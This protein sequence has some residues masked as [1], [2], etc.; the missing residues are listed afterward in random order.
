M[1]KHMAN[2]NYNPDVLNCIANLSNDEVFTPP[3]L[4]N[5]VL[6]LLPQDLF[7]NPNTTFLDPFSKTGV[8][9]REIVKRLDRGLESQIPDRQ[10]RIDHILHTQVYGIAITELTSYL[11]RRSVYCSKHANGKYSVSR[12]NTESGNILYVNR[13]HTW[14]DGKCKYC[15]ASQSVYDRG[16]EAEQYAY[17]F[18]HTD[19]PKQFFGNMK[20]DVIIGNPPYQL[21]DGGQAA[22]AKP[23]YNLFVEQAMKLKPRY[24]TMIIPARWYAGGKGLDSFRASMLKS[25][26]LRKLVDYNNSADC[27][28]G[29]N[30][31]G[32]V[33]YFLWDRD[34][35]GK[36]EIKN[37][38]SQHTDSVP[39][40][41]SL[42]E[43]PILV[44]DNTAIHIIRK[45]LSASK[46]TM[47]MTVQSYSYFAVRS[48]ERGSEKKQKS[49]D[50]VLLSSQG[51]GYYSRAKIEDR[52][53]ILNKYKVI[54][55]YAMSG[56][57]KP[58]SQGDFQVISSL[59]VLAP[60][61][62]CTETYLVLDTFD[63]KK[64]AENLCSYASTKTFRFLLLQALTS[65]HI[66]KDSFLFIPVQD[67]SHSWDDEMLYD[68]YGLREEE[69]AFIESMIRS[70]E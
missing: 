29:V 7:K 34:N 52:Q 45:L 56:G 31:A 59:Q 53:K 27:F 39:E 47:N 44:R 17:M 61:E 25:N 54:I 66:T 14:V 15:G 51:K 33:C 49:D 67:Y 35:P 42:S 9:L 43:F 38:S 57:N 22:S 58:T 16:T 20:F 32:G 50:V 18:I 10:E 3:E 24:L 65:I 6:D 21:S 30:I 36:C 19:N 41:R 8:F 64:Q 37:V 4:A 48:Y 62:V 28:P 40:T 60:N 5:K 63:N 12:F 68:K 13:N 55:T 11:T 26:Q 23:L 1:Q 2:S 70:M 46:K 69:K